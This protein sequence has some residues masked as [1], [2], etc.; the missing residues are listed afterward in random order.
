MGINLDKLIE[1][2]DS[3]NEDDINFAQALLGESE[4]FKE[5]NFKKDILPKLKKTFKLCTFSNGK[6]LIEFNHRTYII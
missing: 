6:V 1:M 3:A 5:V 4:V 2:F